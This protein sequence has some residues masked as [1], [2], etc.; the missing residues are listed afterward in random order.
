MIF[1]TLA[2]RIFVEVDIF[3]DIGQGQK[4]DQGVSC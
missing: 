2:L 1:R 3:F 4:R